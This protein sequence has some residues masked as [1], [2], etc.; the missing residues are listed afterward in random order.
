MFS[1][2]IG[3]KS[4]SRLACTDNVRFQKKIPKI[5]HCGSRSSKYIE[6]GHFTLLG[7]LSTDDDEPRG[8]RPEVIF[9]LTT[10]LRKLDPSSWC[11]LGRQQVRFAVQSEREYVLIYLRS[12]SDRKFISNYWNENWLFINFVAFII[13]PFE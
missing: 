6:L 11:S 7:T 4:C 10:L 2:P 3:L 13:H 8:R 12:V 9:P 1:T 5:S